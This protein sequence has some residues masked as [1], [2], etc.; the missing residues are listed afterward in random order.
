M[1]IHI[2]DKHF[3]LS[4]PG[5]SYHFHI[6][7]GDVIHDHFG[8]P[9][10][11][12]P[13]DTRVSIGPQANQ[14]RR[15]FPDVGRG[16]MRLPAVHIAHGKGTT[17]TRFQYTSHEIGRGKQRGSL[18]GLPATFGAEDDVA[19]LRIHLADQHAGLTAVLDY[20]VFKC[21]AIARSARITNA[22]SDKVTIHRAASAVVDFG[23]DE[24]ELVGLYGNWSRE[25]MV[26]RRKVE[27]GFQG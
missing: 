25:C 23:S 24:K 13:V 16:D 27:H 15:E 18:P 14:A 12:V 1:S 6:A 3:H 26:S 11:T 10:A 22:S 8:A 2:T 9:T 19:T 17:V 4:A 5:L 7:D 20:A 21:G